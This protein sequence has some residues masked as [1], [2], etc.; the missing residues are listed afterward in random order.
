MLCESEVKSTN[1]SFSLGKKS[2]ETSEER[3]RFRRKLL[4]GK[5]RMFIPVV[6]P[7]KWK[8]KSTEHG[9]VKGTVE[10]FKEHGKVEK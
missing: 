2:V 3:E 7:I 9:E 10:S 8:I 5:L 1:E 4:R 6:F